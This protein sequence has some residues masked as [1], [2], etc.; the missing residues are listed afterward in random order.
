MCTFTKYSSA[1][2]IILRR[3]PPVPLLIRMYYM[4]GQQ[5]IE[6]QI[7]REINFSNAESVK[8]ATF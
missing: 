1:V 3:T 8:I 4:L 6:I 7:L 2:K 5:S